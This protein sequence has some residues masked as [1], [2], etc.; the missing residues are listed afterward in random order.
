[1]M[2]SAPADQKAEYDESIKPF[3]TP[4]DTFAAA[5]MVGTDLDTQRAIITVK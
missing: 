5:S 3:L 4:F 2:A 1:M